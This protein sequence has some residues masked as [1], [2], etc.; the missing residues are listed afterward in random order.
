MG[1][2]ASKKAVETDEQV[3]GDLPTKRAFFGPAQST[4]P[5]LCVLPRLTLSHASPFSDPASSAAST[6]PRLPADG[7]GTGQDQGQDPVAPL[8]LLRLPELSFVLGTPLGA[9]LEEVL[10][11]AEDLAPLAP[12]E[13]ARG[14]AQGGASEAWLQRAALLFRLVDLNGSGS[15]SRREC[16]SAVRLFL[17]V[18]ARHESVAREGLLDGSESEAER[19]AAVQLIVSEIWAFAGDTYA[20]GARETAVSFTAF[21][22]FVAHV[23]GGGA[24]S[25]SGDPAP[26]AASSD[27]APPATMPS[28]ASAAST[29]S[30]D[31]GAGSAAADPVTAAADPVAAAPTSAESAAAPTSG[32]APASA[33]EAAASAADAS[34]SASVPEPAPSAAPPAPSSSEEPAVAAPPATVEAPETAAS[35]TQPPLPYRSPAIKSRRRVAY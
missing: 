2:C 6:P 32:L 16:A 35:P 22:A 34:T 33:S 8:S 17:D 23:I 10:R 3:P 30:D 28:A 21:L 25:A 20:G 13:A 19:D 1:V 12:G 15:L 14:A 31:A 26:A 5:L 27:P 9:R 24:G 7:A 4:F 18:A 11:E 29:A